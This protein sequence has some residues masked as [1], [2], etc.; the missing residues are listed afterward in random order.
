VAYALVVNHD[1]WLT[2]LVRALSAQLERGA[3]YKLNVPRR[4]DPVNNCQTFS[5]GLMGAVATGVQTGCQNL[6]ACVR[7][8]LA[9]AMQVFT[10]GTRVS[11][12]ASH[13]ALAP[14][15]PPLHRFT[16]L[17]LAS[18]SCSPSCGLATCTPR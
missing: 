4:N 10:K 18:R 9:R 13:T 5:S 7:V 6:G 16:E 2:K 17:S 11:Y 3:N 14:S 1:R 8:T 12:A 15:A